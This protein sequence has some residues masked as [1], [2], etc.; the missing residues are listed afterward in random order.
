MNTLKAKPLFLFSGFTS[1]VMPFVS[2]VLAV[3]LF[4]SSSYA[5]TDQGEEH[6]K[7][8]VACHLADGQGIP[9]AFPPLKNRLGAFSSSD[10]GRQYIVQTLYGGLMGTISVDGQ[11]YS[12]V[13]PAQAGDL[14]AKEVSD[15]LNYALEKL[16]KPDNWKAF[17]EKE[18]A[19]RNQSKGN[20][21][22][23]GQLRQ[24]LL[25]AQPELK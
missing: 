24:K 7:R 4:S 19:Q 9:G 15:L 22:S 6:F 1:V 21:M 2:L 20:P 23:N 8:C 13:M 16:G 10:L 14:S 12:G 18:I 5:Q 3:V 17:T 25:K 11:M